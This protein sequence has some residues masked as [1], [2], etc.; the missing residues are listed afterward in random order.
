M[1]Q[2]MIYNVSMLVGLFLVGTG[3]AMISVPAALVAVGMIVIGLT[4]FTATRKA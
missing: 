4:L 2:A 3:V 1:T